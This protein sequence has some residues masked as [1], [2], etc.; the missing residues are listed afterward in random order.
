MKK[1]ELQADRELKHK[2]SRRGQHGCA[3]C[4]TFKKTTLHR[5]PDNQ[6]YICQECIN[7]REKGI[8]TRPAEKIVISPAERAITRIGK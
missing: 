5:L 8:P 2:L 3:V 6:G 1:S 4:R 7:K